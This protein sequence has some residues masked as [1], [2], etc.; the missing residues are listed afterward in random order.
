MRRP[1]ALKN[2]D[3]FMG[4]EKEML[5]SLSIKTYSAIAAMTTAGFLDCITICD[6]ACTSDS[7]QAFLDGLRPFVSTTSGITNTLICIT[8]SLRLQTM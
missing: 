8:N 1:L 3:L 2:F 7:I 6:T 5:L 4:E